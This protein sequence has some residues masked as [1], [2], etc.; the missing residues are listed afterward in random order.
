[1]VGGIRY[2]SLASHTP[3]GVACEL[4]DSTGTLRDLQLRDTGRHVT[5]YATALERYAT[6]R[7]TVAY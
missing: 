5:R 2:Y 6:S 1:M 7:A 3:R 4:R